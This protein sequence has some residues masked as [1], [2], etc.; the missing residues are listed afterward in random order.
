MKEIKYS[1]YSKQWFGRRD[2]NTNRYCTFLLQ[3]VPN[4]SINNSIVK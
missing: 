3:D 2:K 4:F 1:K